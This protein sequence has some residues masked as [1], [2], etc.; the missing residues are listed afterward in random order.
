MNIVS[1][2]ALILL[3]KTAVYDKMQCDY[4]CKE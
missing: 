3:T 1:L 4:G 2:F